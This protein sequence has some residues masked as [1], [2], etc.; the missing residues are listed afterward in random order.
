[1]AREGPVGTDDQ[2]SVICGTSCAG[3]GVA[4]IRRLIDLMNADMNEKVANS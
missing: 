3:P 2:R 4:P 1:M